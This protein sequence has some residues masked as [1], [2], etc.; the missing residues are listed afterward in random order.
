MQNSSMLHANRMV[1]IQRMNLEKKAGNRTRRWSLTSIE[2][3]IAR[4]GFPPPSCLWDMLSCHTGFQPFR[5]LTPLKLLQ[6]NCSVLLGSCK[7]FSKTEYHEYKCSWETIWWHSSN[8]PEY[9]IV[10]NL[11]CQQLCYPS[12]CSLIEWHFKHITGLGKNQSHEK[13]IL[14]TRDFQAQN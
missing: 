13:T 2:S 10:Q 9:C 4:E 11:Q 7:E 6:Q 12:I 8:C 3:H 14:E 1:T 5:I